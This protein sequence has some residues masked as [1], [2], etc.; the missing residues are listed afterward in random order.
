MSKKKV[1]WDP[2]WE[3]ILYFWRYYRRINHD[4]GLFFLLE[5]TQEAVIYET[6]IGWYKCSSPLVIPLGNW[7]D[8]THT[9]THTLKHTHT[10]RQWGKQCR[11][12]SFILIA[13]V[14]M[15]ICFIIQP[16]RLFHRWF[17]LIENGIFYHE[18]YLP[19][20]FAHCAESSRFIFSLI[21]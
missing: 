19:T 20:H 1:S 8:C 12:S 6:G 2:A 4:T 10:G 15:A 21:K 18:K 13:C 17:W 16:N 9:E 5:I 3:E 7:G 11:S 14:T